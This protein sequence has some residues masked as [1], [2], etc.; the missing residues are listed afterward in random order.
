MACTLL[1]SAALAKLAD[2]IWFDPQDGVCSN[3]DE[4]IEQAKSSVADL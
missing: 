2:G 4:A 1:A 3:A